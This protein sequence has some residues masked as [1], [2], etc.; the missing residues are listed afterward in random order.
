VKLQSLR[1]F[2][3]T[4]IR[5]LTP[6]QIAE[7]IAKNDKY[8]IRF[9][10]S[11]RGESFND[12][13]YGNFVY[14]VAQ[15]EGDPVILKSDKFPTYHFANVVDDHLMRITHVLRGVEWQISTPKHLMMYRA[16]GWNPPQFGHL[17]LIMNADG[18]K[19]SKRQNDIKLDFYRDKGYFPQSLINYITQAGG[20]FNRE[21]G[22]RLNCYDMHHL[23]QKFDINRINAN[24]SRLNPDLL[25]ELNQI[26]LSNHMEDP[27]KCNALVVEVRK[28]IKDKYPLNADQL[29]LD[30]DHIINV[31]RWG[32]KRIKSINELA[33][34]HL[35]FLWVLPKIA[36]DKEI[37]LNEGNNLY[38]CLN[39]II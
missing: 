34:E 36:K 22:E 25:D 7:K 3:F 27:K 11:D 9:K 20:G 12:L 15:N 33:E 30:D 6:K 31:L 17:P 4:S 35:S 13:V 8:C 38:F 14:Y 16:L 37:S 5:D 39:T 32:L 2:F 29:D 26:E 24:S 19:L 21:P 10:L 18:S 1:I 23:T 28:L